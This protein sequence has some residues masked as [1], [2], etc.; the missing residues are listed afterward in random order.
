[1]NNTKTILS[2]GRTLFVASLLF[3]TPTLQ[4]NNEIVLQE[5]GGAEVT[6][7]QD[8]LSDT[9]TKSDTLV[10]E[11]KFTGRKGEELT[12]EA[13]EL[14]IR[15]SMTGV[16]KT[17]VIYLDRIDLAVEKDINIEVGGIN[18]EGG[19][20]FWGGTATVGSGNGPLPAVFEIMPGPSEVE[21]HDLK[22]GANS[23]LT[24]RFYNRDR[25]NRF[26]QGD[27]AV[28]PVQLG[29]SLEI[30]PGAKIR[31]LF[32]QRLSEP[33]P[34]G[35]SMLIRAGQI[36]GEAPA[37]SQVQGTDVLDLSKLSCEVRDNELVLSVAP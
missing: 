34:P 32:D 9:P 13:G 31:L 11:G 30:A 10:V 29:G 25:V 16:R 1:M 3:S 4:A 17:P 21:G 14:I 15:H 22:L 20:L 37:I 26:V 18:V 12:L 6:D 8:A 23:V 7:V 36:T 28:K 27:A 19:K 35:D 33:L 24:V 2:A 5:L